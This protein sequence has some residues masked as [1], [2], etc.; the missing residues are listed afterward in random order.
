MQ[1][2]EFLAVYSD[3]DAKTLPVLVWPGCGLI[4]WPPAGS[5]EEIPDGIGEAGP[6][7]LCVTVL[8][9]RG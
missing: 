9:E 2:E 5:V 7:P 4:V 6:V 1:V 8:L 3:E